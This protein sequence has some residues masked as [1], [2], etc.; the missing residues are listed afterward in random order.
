MFMSCT[1]V[2]Y[3]FF[4]SFLEFVICGNVS[5]MFVGGIN[6]MYVWMFLNELPR[7]VQRISAFG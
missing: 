2:T 1:V 6:L 3:V 5:C 4:V 7:D